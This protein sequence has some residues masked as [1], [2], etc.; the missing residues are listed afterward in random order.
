MVS[1]IPAR[2]GSKRI[3]KKN[4]KLLAEKP[5][6]AYTIEAS[7]NS[8]FINRTIVST[9][10]EEIASVAREYGAEVMMR[11][12]EL[13]EDDISTELVLIHVIEQLEKQDYRTDYIVLLQPTTPLRKIDIIN[14][15]ISIA[16]KSNA[17]SVLSVCEVQHY[18]LSGYFEGEDYKLEYDKRPFSNNMPKKYRENGALY[19]TKKDFL[20][21]NR[22]RIGGKIRSVVMNE[23]DSIDIDEIEDFELAEKIIKGDYYERN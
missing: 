15:G 7:L 8:E 23:V 18:Y 20:V 5:L 10:D 11:P 4:I 9:D 22:N 21:K 12:K 1:I 6:I 17:D 2:G 13:A 16:L 19:I 14:K 3:I